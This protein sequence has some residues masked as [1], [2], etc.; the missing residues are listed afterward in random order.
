MS[1][2]W[3]SFRPSFF[4]DVY[5]LLQTVTAG[6]SPIR[7]LCLG[8]GAEAESKRE[9]LPPTSN[10]NHE[11]HGNPVAEEND[12]GK[13]HEKIETTVCLIVFL[14][15]LGLRISTSAHGRR[16][17][18]RK[19]SENKTNDRRAFGTRKRSSRLDS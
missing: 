3:R 12:H 9:W 10:E 7:T 19:I 18:M 14:S 13:A 2:S 11:N 6:L 4:T 5:V 17:E 15:G 8:F 1:G 16:K